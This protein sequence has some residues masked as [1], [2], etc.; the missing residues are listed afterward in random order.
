[1]L[2]PLWINSVTSHFYFPFGYDGSWIATHPSVGEGLLEV[3]SGL[4]R[5]LFVTGP[6]CESVQ[7]LRA[8]I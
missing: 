1:M 8:S 5:G 6:H 3:W 7:I 2:L 4:V